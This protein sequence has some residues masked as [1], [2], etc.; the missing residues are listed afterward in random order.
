[1][2][3]AKPP[4]IE[5]G[6]E[7]H[8]DPQPDKQPWD[9]PVAGP[10]IDRYKTSFPHV[11]V[12]Q[13]E[14]FHIEKRGPGGVPARIFG[15][16]SLD[17]LRAHNEE[18]TRWIQVGN[19]LL[20]C[21]LVRHEE[22][23]PGF[24]QLREEAL[25]TLHQY[26]EH[27]KPASVKRAALTYL[28]LVEIPIPEGQIGF[29]VEDFFRLHVEVPDGVFGAVGYFS[30]QLVF[31]KKAGGTDQLSLLFSTAPPVQDRR[32]CRFQMHWHCLCEDVNSLDKGVI[33]GR[34]ETAHQRL[35]ECFR[36]SFTDKGWA[37]FQPKD[38]Q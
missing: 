31:P 2:K 7:F 15:Q 24:D 34:L 37:L 3:L 32:A 10:F 27:F 19:D 18:G 5:V 30:L 36:A 12:L 38:N 16:I 22:I 33:A 20:V 25:A 29:R 1:L 11:E 23:Y 9:L 4:V 14:Q 21:S 35:R 13:A 26:V 28:D 17:R 8:F 6:I